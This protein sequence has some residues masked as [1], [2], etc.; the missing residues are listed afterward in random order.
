LDALIVGYLVY[1]IYK[2]LKG[3]VGFNIFIGI[4]LLSALYATVRYFKMNLLST[5]LG[6]FFQIGAVIL[7]IVFQ[8]EVRRFLTM[9]GENT[10]QRRGEFL[11]KFFGK[12]I[13]AV[14]EKISQTAEQ[15]SSAMKVLS[16]TKTG[17]LIVIV[18]ESIVESFS[19]SGVIVDAKLSQMLVENI[20]AKNAPLH[21]GA[22][23]IYGD[24]IHSAS[25]ILP[26]SN[27]S[28]INKNLGLRH[29]AALG[30]TEASNAVAYIVSEETGKMSYAHKGKLYTDIASKDL[31][32]LL[33][34]HLA[35]N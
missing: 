6:S 21:D 4:L 12:E 32:G 31:T 28:S 8:P 19:G 16:R 24:R 2:R 1:F 18:Q 27:N 33:K 14:D 20:F 5:L 34:S 9:F 30:I 29:R 13:S 7:V 23:I 25:V 35:L 3:S 11:D 15:I 22:M 17:A 10:L 26:V